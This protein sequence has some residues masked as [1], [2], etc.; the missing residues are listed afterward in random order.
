MCDAINCFEA[1]H[2]AYSLILDCIHRGDYKLNLVNF[3]LWVFSISWFCYRLEDMNIKKCRKGRFTQNT[4]SGIKPTSPDF[5]IHL[6]VI[7]LSGDCVCDAND[8]SCV[9][10]VVSVTTQTT[11]SAS[12]VEH[13]VCKLPEKSSTLLYFLFDFPVQNALR[14]E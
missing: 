11:G 1:T 12:I 3:H 8:R 5:C 2:G 9:A 6:N 10:G 14:V 4:W 7:E 13:R